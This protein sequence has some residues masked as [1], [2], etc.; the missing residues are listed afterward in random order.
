MV[1]NREYLS[2]LADG[3][4]D[5]AQQRAVLAALRS[6]AP[7]AQTWNT[8]HMIGEVLREKCVLHMDVAGR[9][10]QTLSHE[11]TQLVPQAR[12]LHVS[13]PTRWLAVA[14]AVAVVA[15]STRLLQWNG[16]PT[17]VAPVAQSAASSAPTQL[18]QTSGPPEV[19]AY[20]AMHHQWS[21]LSG[22]QAVDYVE[23]GAA[24]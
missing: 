1:M 17:T 16:L 18:A 11:P 5:E 24:R 9:V 20:V 21:P 19:A 4:L 2:A 7:A 22:F 10:A 12:R 6:D 23:A 3:E 13:T 8:Y 14:A 15:L